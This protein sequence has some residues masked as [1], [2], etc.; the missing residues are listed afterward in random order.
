M[1]RLFFVC[2]ALSDLD[3]KSCTLGGCISD[4]RASLA[5]HKSGC[6]NF[7]AQVFK[8]GPG[9][10]TSTHNAISVLAG[11]VGESLDPSSLPAHCMARQPCSER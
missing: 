7:S 6:Q 9:S 1:A 2:L 10:S 4:S 11:R 8:Y 5:S 3:Y